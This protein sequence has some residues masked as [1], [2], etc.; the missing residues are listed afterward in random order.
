MSLMKESNKMKKKVIFMIINMNIGGTE[1][2]L[3]SMIDEMPKEKYDITILMLEKYGGFLESI[4]PRVRK[5]YLDGF[6]NMKDILN[7]PPKEVVKNH[8]KKG[9]I[10]KGLSLFI[11]YILSKVLNMK[12][13]LFKYLLKSIPNLKNK[14]DIAIAYA[15]PMDFIS[16]FVIHKIKAVKK[17]QWIHF[18]VTKIGFHGKFAEKIYHQFDRLYVVSE[19]ARMKLINKFP[20]LLDKTKVFFNI[21]SPN[22]IISQSKK[23]HGFNDNFS[24]I[25]ILTVGRL[26]VEKGQDL[27][28]KVLAKLRK[29]GYNVKWYCVGEGGARQQYEKLID[30]Y[31]LK[32]SFVLL[33]QS[34]NPY[35]YMKQC[36]IY[37]QPS[38]Y[39]GYCITLMEAK[40]F[41]KPIVTT[42]VNGAREQ[43]IDGETGLIVKIDKTELVHAI[44]KLID[45][46]MLKRRLEDNLSTDSVYSTVNR[47]NLNRLIESAF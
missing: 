20:T 31:N 18:D 7:R 9:L 8:L 10:I 11:I 29:E 38:R 28:I 23:G 12:S 37:V 47:E 32:D 2:A 39:E 16:Y 21:V 45:D 30:K 35:P 5:K 15:G 27:A 36:D 34:S 41:V 26:S 46:E 6:C 40:Y 14:Y 4:P 25:R 17:I 3:L 43:I 13:I 1:K 44:K 22:N 19:E 42:D 24:G 33:G